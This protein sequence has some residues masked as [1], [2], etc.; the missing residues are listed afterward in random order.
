MA[1]W[2]VVRDKIQLFPHPNADSLQLGKVGQFQVVVQKGLYEDGDEVLFAPRHSILPDYLAEGF[3]SY[4]KGKEKNRVGS[5]RLRGEL[6]MGVILPLD[7]LPLDTTSESDLAQVLGIT[8]FEP[9]IPIELAGQVEAAPCYIS[10]HDV[11]QFGI[12]ASEFEADEE[13]VVTEKIHGSQVNMALTPDGEFVLSSKGILSRSQVI[14]E[15]DTNVYWRAARNCEIQKLLEDMQEIYSRKNGDDMIAKPLVQA[16]GEVI[17][18][19]G[20]KWLY[21]QDP[22]SP[23]VLLFDLRVDGVS[24]SVT[25]F[26]ELSGMLSGE[27]YCPAAHWVPF[28]WRGPFS[29]M[30]ADVLCKG[31][32]QV[33]GKELHIREGVVIRPSKP[34]LATDGTPLLVKKINPAYAKKE[35][36]EEPQ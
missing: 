20:G 14:L 16:I 1:Q 17:P 6:S 18:V 8:K 31:N 27:T 5:V 35:T 11:E 12:Y 4:L 29:A 23:V 32:E 15:S 22:N 36:G 33:S 9:P 2:Q 26:T 3:R 19:Q 25:S 34:K 10:Q 28:I 7:A 13:V 30:P 24:L 21:G